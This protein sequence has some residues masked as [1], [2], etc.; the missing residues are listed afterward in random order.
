MSQPVTVIAR[1]QA[2]PDRVDELRAALDVMIAAT[3]Q[4]AGYTVY[5]LH[6]GADDPTLFMFHEI[7][8]TREHHQVHAQTDHVNAFRERASTLLDGTIQ[9]DVVHKVE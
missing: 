4:E 9:V 2:K 7:W 1:M 3:R 6:V 8:E 5:D